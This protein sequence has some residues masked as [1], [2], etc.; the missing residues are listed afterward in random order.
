VI[1]EAEERTWSSTQS[2]GREIVSSLHPSYPNQ[3]WFASSY[4]Q[5]AIAP[6]AGSNRFT[7]KWF[8]QSLSFSSLIGSAPHL[9]AQAYSPHSP[10]TSSLL[11]PLYYIHLL[12][13]ASL[14]DPLNSLYSLRSFHANQTA[15]PRPNLSNDETKSRSLNLRFW[16]NSPNRS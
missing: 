4:H 10:L 12:P 16:E 14:V 6:P 9:Y 5:F 1:K 15:L 8:S 3:L 2:F 13:L 11:S 7:L